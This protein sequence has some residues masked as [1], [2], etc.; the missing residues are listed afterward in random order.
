MSIA[1]I[2]FPTTTLTGYIHFTFQGTQNLCEEVGITLTKV[3][4]I[5][6]GNQIF[7]SKG[8]LSKDE[9]NLTYFP[10]TGVRSI[11]ISRIGIYGSYSF[12]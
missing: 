5:H 11:A 8:I 2:V 3:E 6:C 9:K 1:K 7:T 4:T 12:V 10:N